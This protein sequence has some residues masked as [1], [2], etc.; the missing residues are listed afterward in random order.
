MLD[1]IA[2]PNDA[3]RVGDFLNQGLAD[4]KWTE[5][6][7]AV[8]FV[9]RSGTRHINHALK[10]FNARAST[11]VR[12]SIGVDKGGT[13]F[14]GATDLL[15]SVGTKGQVWVFKNPNAL[16][17]PKIYLFKNE[18]S[19][20]VI[21]GSV[22]LTQGGLYE[23]YEG[24]VRA[25]L[26]L[27]DEND[28]NFLFAIESALDFWSIPTSDKVCLPLTEPLLGVLAM[29]GD[30]PTEN[31]SST[32]EKAIQIAKKAEHQGQSPFGSLKTKSAPK[33]PKQPKQPKQLASATSSTTL[34]GAESG[35]VSSVVPLTFGMTFQETDI[36]V[37]KKNKRKDGSDKQGRSPEIFIPI[38]ALDLKP[39]FWGWFDKYNPD[40]SKYVADTS[41]ASKLKNKEW[42]A[43]KQAKTRLK[44]RPLDKLDW[45]NVAI[46]LFGHT[47]LS[48][49]TIWFNPKKTDI[50]MRHPDFRAMASVDDIMI[51]RQG[52]IGSG[53]E[54]LIQVIPKNDPN[55]ATFLARLT[56]TVPHS[57]KKIGYF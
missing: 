17:H 57:L 48:D 30:L 1:F 26:D 12:I 34:S 20:D 18:Y 14:E 23:N 55:Y 28:K 41:W 10:A 47:T 39:I 42:I 29:C 15:D 27:T 21:V 43:K 31:E 40:P 33:I 22:N 32:A 45:N 50:R 35:T 37:G 7:A 16:Y 6:R 38:L 52:V 53:Y 4:E 51:V 11:R 36:G 24:S 56:H 54:Y 13:S 3:F 46:Q 49:A 2:H 44:P 9:K 5:F 8:A 19:A 25:Q